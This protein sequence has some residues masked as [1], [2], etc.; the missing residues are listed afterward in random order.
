MA[1]KRKRAAYLRAWARLGRD[2]E[3]AWI[4]CARKGLE[5]LLQDNDAFHQISSHATP[6]T[7]RI[8]MEDL[9]RHD[10]QWMIKQREL[11]RACARQMLKDYWHP[12]CNKCA[13]SGEPRWIITLP[14]QR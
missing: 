14:T 6:F 9:K 8:T 10:I 2:E 12:S 3:A 13:R 4:R 5:P 7:W 1:F 11:L